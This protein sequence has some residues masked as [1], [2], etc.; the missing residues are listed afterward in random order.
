MQETLTRADS[1]T[2][3]AA[4]LQMWEPKHFKNAGFVHFEKTSEGD[5]FLFPADAYDI[6]PEG[7]AIM[8]I[9]RCISNF[10]KGITDKAVHED[11]LLFG[12]LKKSC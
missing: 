6:L 4:M 9:Y 12:F 8:D 5:L 7:L 2:S 11:V 10:Q 3:F 1:A